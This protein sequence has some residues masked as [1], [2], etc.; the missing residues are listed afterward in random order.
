MVQLWKPYTDSDV[1]QVFDLFALTGTNKVD[2]AE[3]GT[4]LRALGL[5]P[6]EEQIGDSMKLLQ[7]R[8]AKK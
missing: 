1:S 6:S 5:N 2:I 4:I 3:I 8:G 7:I